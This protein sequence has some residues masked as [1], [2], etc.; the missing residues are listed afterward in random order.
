MSQTYLHT[1]FQ[2]SSITVVGATIVFVK[3]SDRSTNV[4]KETSYEKEEEEEE[5]EEDAASPADDASLAAPAAAAAAAPVGR[6]PRVSTKA[7]S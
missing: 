6:G 5:E 2:L 3:V 4:H 7:I 1:K